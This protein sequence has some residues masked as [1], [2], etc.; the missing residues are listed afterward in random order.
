MMSHT[1][2]PARRRVTRI[3]TAALLAGLCALTC[4]ALTASL[5]RL[6]V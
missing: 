4:L 5:G 1:R 6:P 3:K 2:P